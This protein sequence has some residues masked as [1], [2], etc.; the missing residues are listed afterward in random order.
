MKK[1]LLLAL[2][3]LLIV[4]CVSNQ[5]FRSEKSRMN[6]MESALAQNNTELSVLRKE[7]MQDRKMGGSGAKEELEALTLMVRQISDEQTKQDALMQEDIAYLMDRL[8]S[9]PPAEGAATMTEPQLARR[10]ND[11]AANLEKTTTEMN[12]KISGIEKELATLKT[13]NVGSASGA[14]SS[15]EI[16]ELKAQMEA[17]RKAQEAEI[18]ALRTA[19]SKENV[20]VSA[21]KPAVSEAAG[22]STV[23]GPEAERNEYEAGRLEYNNGNY[24][25]AIQQLETFI[26]RYPNSDYAGNAYYWKGESKYAKSEWS[27]ALK[28]FQVVVSRYP[29]SWK[30]ADSQLKIGM[31]YVNMGNHAE[32]RAALNNLKR[33]YPYYG[34]MDLVNS[35]LSQLD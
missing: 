16:A 19:I 32:A 4:G 18:A 30:V 15:K 11:L 33:E 2:V 25:Q 31:C 9:N 17:Q 8:D 12:G 10:L 24:D 3:P 23:T 29:N 26:S 7:I 20:S 6:K 5:A 27:Q 22:A 35:Y 21:V 14:V 1:L 13:G 34:R 28:E